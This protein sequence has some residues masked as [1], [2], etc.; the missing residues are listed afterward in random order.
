[1]SSAIPEAEGFI[2]GDLATRCLA[3]GC[4]RLMTDLA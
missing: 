3:L 1:M 2:D 4:C